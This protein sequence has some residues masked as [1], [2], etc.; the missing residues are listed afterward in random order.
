M[1]VENIPIFHRG[2]CNCIRDIIKYSHSFLFCSL[3]SNRYYCHYSVIIME[4]AIFR[5]TGK[6]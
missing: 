5:E 4:Q 6:F 3:A 2:C 1:D